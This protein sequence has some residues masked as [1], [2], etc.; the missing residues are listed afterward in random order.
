LVGFDEPVE[1]VNQFDELVAVV[2]VL[3][4]LVAVVLFLFPDSSFGF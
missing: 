1:L 4:E 3:V 2:L